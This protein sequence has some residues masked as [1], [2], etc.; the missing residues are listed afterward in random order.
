MKILLINS[1]HYIRGGAD[2]VY[3]DTGKLLE[4]HGHQ[5][6]YFSSKGKKTLTNENLN[7]FYPE[8]N[9]NKSSLITKISNVKNFIYNDKSYKNLLEY[10]DRVKPD[11][12]HV[13][14]F[15][16]G[17]TVAIL[18]ALKEKKIPIVHT[19]HDF[20]LI[21]PATLFLDNKNNICELCKDGH[22]LRATTKKC[23]Q[24]G[25]HSSFM[26]SMD[27]YFRKIYLRPLDLINHFIFVS[28]FSR[29]KHI[30][31]EYKYMSKSSVLYN[32]NNTF[33]KIE[34][35]KG[36]YFLYCGRLSREKGIETL[37]KAAILSKISLKI[38]GDGP[39]FEEY[40]KL[41]LK[42][43]ELVGFKHGD[44]LRSLVR[45]SSF[46]IVPSEVYENNPLT[47]IESYSTG[48]PVIASRIGGIPEIVDNGETGY[49]FEAKSVKDLT[50][51]INIAKSINDDEYFRIS[52]NTIKFAKMHFNSENHYNKLI[53]IYTATIF[54]DK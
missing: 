22:Y 10:L 54:D 7:Y 5:V 2:V 24:K 13:H 40:A 23:S 4:K 8:I 37:I 26:L 31:F 6:F 53:E 18:K 47:I 42:N 21:C 38:V 29:D 25:Y 19:V 28:H 12:A 35:K 48:K 27:A 32:F 33:Q 1:V 14:L 20:R 16:G 9:Y 44:E 39:L 34:N 36:D 50:K 17:G 49:L 15:M 3:F 45:N 43:I 46:V 52:N 51:K 11:I 41:N 30:E